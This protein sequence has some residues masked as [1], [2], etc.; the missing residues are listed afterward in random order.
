MRVA[1]PMAAWKSKSRSGGL[2][3]AFDRPGEGLA[4]R[5]DP[6]D[7]G[8]V[9]LLR[10]EARRLDLDADAEIEDVENL[11]DRLEPLRVDAEGTAARIGGDEGARIPGAS[12]RGPP[13]RSA[14]IASRT[15]VR[16]TP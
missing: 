5:V 2:V 13:E 11:L 1:V 3:A 16:L 12:R 4:D 9:A 7:V 10:R 8:L 15:T 14:A 6:R